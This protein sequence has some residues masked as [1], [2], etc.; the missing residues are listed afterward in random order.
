MIVDGIALDSLAFNITTRSGWD[1]LPEP[2]GSNVRV[3]GRH[4][5]LWRRKDFAEGRMVL[6]CF[7]LGCDELGRIP[8]GSDAEVEYRRN[9]DKL[10]AVFGRRDG[11]LT[12]E[13]TQVDGSS[14]LNYGEVTAAITPDFPGSSPAATF[15]V[16]LTFPDPLWVDAAGPQTIE[17]A[18]SATSPR[19]HRLDAL[20]GTAAPI[21]D[22][23]VLVEGPAAIPRVT[24][25][26]SGA[27]AEL[28]RNLAA[29][30][31]WRLRAG[32]YVSETGTGLGYTGGAATNRLTQTV[33]SASP[34]YLPLT[35][36]P[37]HRM[38][39]SLEL[40]GSGFGATTRLRVRATR[41][42]F[43]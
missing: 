38:T 1:Y 42:F 35:P 14:R 24:D 2:V 28:G 34:R 22:A 3:P 6:D 33:I 39:P 5:S 9:L 40:S 16:E 18:A 21:L 17:P 11:L 27:Y 4:G 10:L 20:S 8:L 12:V 32:D 43:A 41:R 30:E 15:R 23:V 29:G 19:T 25:V 37:A 7:V 26:K 13:K 31:T 36:D